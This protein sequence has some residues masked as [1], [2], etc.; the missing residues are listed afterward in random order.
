MYLV[1]EKQ[2]TMFFHKIHHVKFYCA[3]EVHIWEPVDFFWDLQHAQA[4]TGGQVRR[5]LAEF[6]LMFIYAAPVNRTR[7]SAYKCV[8]ML[9]K[10]WAACVPEPT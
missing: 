9:T 4:G 6:H 5:F 10:L 3:Q 1:A 2:V 8:G 7:G